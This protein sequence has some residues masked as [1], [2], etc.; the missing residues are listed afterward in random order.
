MSSIAMVFPEEVLSATDLQHPHGGA[1]MAPSQAREFLVRDQDELERA[2]DFLKGLKI[3]EAQIA[4]TFDPQITRAHALHK[5]LLA[6]KRKFTDPLAVA[7]R[8]IKPKIIAYL[9]E[10]DRKRREAESARLKA[11]AAATEIADEALK[12]AEALKEGGDMRGADAV[13]NTAYDQAQEILDKAPDVPVAARAEGLSL[14]VV[15]KFAII[16]ANALPREYLK[17]DEVK[18]GRIV[19]ALKSQAQIPGVR[20]WSEKTTVTKLGARN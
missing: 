18:I 15:W 14:S 17:P 1:L 16:N 13:I 12:K 5:S 8:I 7:E 2:N 3:L 11:E 9:D 4:E 10:E 20:I 6:E 19:R